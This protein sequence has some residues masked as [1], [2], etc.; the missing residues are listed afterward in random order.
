MPPGSPLV[1]SSGTPEQVN[2]ADPD[3]LALTKEARWSDFLNTVS[4]SPTKSTKQTPENI[5]A[6]RQDTC[7]VLEL[8]MCDTIPNSVQNF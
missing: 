2:T 3:E 6:V 8:Q 5:N 4:L 7:L 1:V